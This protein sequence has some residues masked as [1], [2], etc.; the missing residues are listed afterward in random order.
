MIRVSETM[1]LEAAVVLQAPEFG[2]AVGRRAG[3]H[4]VDGG[5]AHR[6]DTAPVA[7]EHP[8]QVRARPRGPQGPQFGHPVLGTRRQKLVVGRH[9]H[10]VDVLMGG[11]YL[12]G[13][14]GDEWR[15]IRRTSCGI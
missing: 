15:G 6:P 2:R 12:A 8:Q 11:G 13:Y 3:Q 7:P 4:L 5:E 1:Y 14:H 9:R 10:A